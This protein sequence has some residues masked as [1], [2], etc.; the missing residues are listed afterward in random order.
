LLLAVSAHDDRPALEALQV[1]R[2]HDIEVEKPVASLTLN[3]AELVAAS[4]AE[5]C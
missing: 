3:A 2:G 4:R 1:R 5:R